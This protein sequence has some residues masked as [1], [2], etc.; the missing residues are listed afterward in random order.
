MGRQ[1]ATYW[2]PNMS[3]NII[4]RLTKEQVATKKVDLQY[5]L[6]SHPNSLKKALEMADVSKS[7]YYSWMK[8]DTEL[9]SA[10]K[11]MD[12]A[13]LDFVKE[14]MFKRI[15]EGSDT[16]IKFYLETKGADDGFNKIKKIEKT[17][18]EQRV[19]QVTAQMDKESW[20]SLAEKQQEVFGSQKEIDTALA[21]KTFDMEDGTDGQ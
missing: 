15:D 11:N 9:I 1:D 13:R 10:V 3:D 21:Q 14:A 6:I 7:T 4:P 12:A 8:N 18:T 16:L 19:L 5:A 20:T 2:R 17:V